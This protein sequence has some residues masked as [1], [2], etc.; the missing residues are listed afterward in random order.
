MTTVAIVIVAAWLIILT[1]VEIV[2]VGLFIDQIILARRL[3]AEDLE[4][5]ERLINQAV[6]Q[7]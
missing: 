7:L 6:R 5:L 2:T 1:I 4:K 3:Q